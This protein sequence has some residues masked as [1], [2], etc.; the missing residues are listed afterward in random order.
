M[1]TMASRGQAA[2]ALV[3]MSAA[4][5]TVTVAC[6]SG[7]ARSRG[8][9]TVRVSAS[10]NGEAAKTG[11]QVLVDA[12]NALAAVP[13]V[14]ITGTQTADGQTQ[15][16]DLRVQADGLIGTAQT[17]DATSELLA[18]DGKLYSKGTLSPQATSLLPKSV[19]AQ[20]AGRWTYIDPA[21][22]T[23]SLSMSS[24]VD[25]PMNLKGFAAGL[26]K[27]EKG[28]TV[29]AAVT[30]DTLDGQPVVVVSE[31]NGSRLFVA[32]TGEPLPLK[33]ISK[34][35]GDSGFDI[36]GSGTFSYG[37]DPVKLQAPAGAV[38]MQQILGKLMPPEPTLLP[39]NFPTELL[40]LLPSPLPTDLPSA[41]VSQLRSLEQQKSGDVGGSPA[42]APTP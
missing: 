33:I 34:E 9:A 5:M 14:H 19:E 22:N 27:L 32:A 21:A 38:S 4:A 1:P 37:D 18:V 20:L 8:Q 25:E 39:S 40:S 24:S 30:T 17:S 15:K 13:A 29:A 35:Q 10:P 2:G 12:T 6:S 3:A 16:L 28:V 41:L 31:S 42:P 23:S 7:A 26:R 36:V 11:M